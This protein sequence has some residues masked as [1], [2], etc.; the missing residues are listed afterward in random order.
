M[1]SIEEKEASF[2]DNWADNTDLS[3][4]FVDQAFETRSSP[5]NRQIVSWMGIIRGKKILEIGCGLGEASVYFAKKGAIVTATDIS[6]K[7]V[8][9][10]QELAKLHHVTVEG[11]VVS[12]NNLDNIPDN[13]FDFTYAGNLLHHVDV[14][15]CVTQLKPKLRD[16]GVAFFWDPIAYNPAINIYRRLATKV[17][18]EDEHPLKVEDI[19]AIKAV[20]TKVELEYFWLTSLGVFFWYYLIKRID[21]NKERYWKI[22]LQDS[23]KISTYLK[24]TQRLDSFLFKVFPP[25]RY[26]AW[27]VVIKAHK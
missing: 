13:C 19:K 27:N 6:P 25:F 11:K 21:P 7:M 17:R 2:H 24:I 5:E 26:L 18:T 15:R 14:A 3:S 4:V 8:E 22:I 9:K 20:F 23:D 16:G 12:A 1:N 10:V